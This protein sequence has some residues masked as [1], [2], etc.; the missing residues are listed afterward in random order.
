[1]GIAAYGA[2]FAVG[3]PLL[4]R[5]G[6]SASIW[7]IRLPAYGNAVGRRGLVIGAGLAVIGA[8]MCTLWSDG[9][10][11]AMSPFPPGRLVTSGLYALIPHPIYVGAVTI[12]LGYALFTRS[13]AGLWMVTPL[14]A[15]AAASFVLGYEREATRIR[16]GALPQPRLRLPPDERRQGGMSGIGSRSTRSS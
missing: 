2:A 10:G 5:S 11:L 15:L 7:I 16:F 9:G 6:C 3:L 14:L 8:A 12:C 13:A 1:M 4:S